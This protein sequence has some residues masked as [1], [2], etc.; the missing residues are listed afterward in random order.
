M[1]TFGKENIIARTIDTF[2]GGY[3]NNP[4]D[5]G[6]P[7]NMGI[8]LNTLRSFDDNATVDDIKHLPKAKA[9][10]IYSSLYWDK[11]NISQ[12]P[13]GIQDVTFDTYVQHNPET[14][15]ILLQTAANKLGANISVDGKLGP[16]TVAA[17]GRIDAKL[18]RAT[19]LTVRRD[20]YT[21]K[22]SEHP[23]QAQFLKGWLNRINALA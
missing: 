15:T 7:T 9:I 21:V 22:A 19:L 23:S 2:E 6:G 11:Y 3:V 14:A 1:E 17:I 20:Y 13:E 10:S 4:A 5:K 18:M 16:N 12:L 8:T